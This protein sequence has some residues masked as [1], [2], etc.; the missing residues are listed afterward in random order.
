[1]TC[2][3]PWQVRGSR[4]LWAL[5]FISLFV[6][7][8]TSNN[9]QTKGWLLHRRVWQQTQSVWQQTSN[10][11]GNRQNKGWLCH[12]PFSQSRLRVLQ[13]SN[14]PSGNRQNH[15]HT[16]DRAMSMGVHSMQHT[17]ASLRQ[18]QTMDTDTHLLCRNQ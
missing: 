2:S 8:L 16:V 10:R 9:R 15:C 11:S 6:I 14:R 13:Q 5:L 17:I 4:K 3:I 1:M 7:S 18:S 12:R